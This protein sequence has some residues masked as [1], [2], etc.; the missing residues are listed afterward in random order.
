MLA[1]LVRLL[2]RAFPWLSYDYRHRR[3]KRVQFCPACANK[4]RVTMSYAPQQ[5]QIVCQCPICLACWGYNPV[6]RSDV[7]ATV[8]RE[9]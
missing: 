8:N 4:V 9:E 5:K 1:R 3:V 7:W 6:I 2:I